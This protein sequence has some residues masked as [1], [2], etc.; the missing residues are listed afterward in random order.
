M[1]EAMQCTF[2]RTDTL[3]RVE[4]E[5]HL[6]EERVL[7][8][9]RMGSKGQ[10]TWDLAEE[11]RQARSNSFLGR[12][13]RGNLEVHFAASPPIP[14]YPH[15]P[16][17]TAWRPW[18][19]VPQVGDGVGVPAEVGV[20]WEAALFGRGSGRPS[21]VAS[22]SPL[23]HQQIAPP[24]TL[25]QGISSPSS[26]KAQQLTHP[27]LDAEDATSAA[28]VN[29]RGRLRAGMCPSLVS[30]TT[31]ANRAIGVSDASAARLCP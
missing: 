8:Y 30:L 6:H 24:R 26:L 2:Q 1:R 11:G 20:S 18:V 4:G 3:C 14:H 17:A 29:I 16:H 22:F 13:A 28:V 5:D 9:V 10:G 23:N 12:T 19:R 21:E 15:R 25:P 27:R 31:I 7:T